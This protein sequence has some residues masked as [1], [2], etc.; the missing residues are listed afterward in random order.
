VLGALA[1]PAA[2]LAGSFLDPDDYPVGANPTSLAYGDFDGDGRRDLVVAN[3]DDADVSI[4][5]VNTLNP[6]FEQKIDYPVGA[7]PEAV[8]VADFSGDARVDIAVANEVDKTISVLEADFSGGTF[9]PKVDLYSGG[10]PNAIVAARFGSGGSDRPS[11]L[12]VTSSESSSVFVTLF[13]SGG[14]PAAPA[15]Y[16]VG[17]GPTALVAQNFN[18]DTKVD[19]ATANSG[20]GTISVLPGLSDGTFGDKLDSIVGG[21]PLSLA[22]LDFNSDGKLDLLV[23]KDDG[24]VSALRGKGGGT[25]KLQ[26]T[27]YPVGANPV[28]IVLGKFNGGHLLDFATANYDDGSVSVYEG[29]ADGSFSSRRDY[30]VGGH[31]SE[32]VAIDGQSLAVANAGDGVVSV[33]VDD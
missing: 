15:E 23:A 2:L 10:D 26:G 30:V 4:L 3:H 12:A 32:I 17:A 7:G 8:A 18:G 27:P 5:E 16:T 28:S 14:I 22:A 20:D 9:E 11:S 13:S 33:L 1:V 24:T 31:P 29:E 25:F 19:I 6:T 21:T